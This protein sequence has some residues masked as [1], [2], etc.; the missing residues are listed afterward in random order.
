MK[1]KKAVIGEGVLMLYRIALVV[2]IAFMIIGVSAIFYDY[3]I[4]V[5][6]VESRILAREVMHCIAPDGILDLSQFSGEDEK[7][8][9]DYC[10]I[11]DNKR[12]YVMLTIWKDEIG[13]FSLTDDSN[14]EKKIKVLEHGDSGISWIKLAIDNMDE[15]YVGLIRRYEPGIY[16]WRG[17]MNVKNSG[18]NMQKGVSMVVLTAEGA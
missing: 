13:S 1:N 3:H 15:S 5:R 9:L 14:Q 12:F 18:E 8:L 2:L 7:N 11:K 16:Y 4:D 10:G 17:W 6:D